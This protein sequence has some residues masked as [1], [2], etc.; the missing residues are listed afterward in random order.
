MSLVAETLSPA[1]SPASDG[2]APASRAR[3]ALEPVPLVQGELSLRQLD[4]DIFRPM[5]SFP[6]RRWWVAISIT[7]AMAGI[8]AVSL[9]WTVLFGIGTWGNNQPVGWGFGIIN[10]V[11]W[12][13]IGHA[14]TLIS[15]ILYLLRQRWRTGIARFAEAMTLFA[16]FCALQFPLLHTGR[17]WLAMFWLIPYPNGQ[18][19]YQ[20]FT[21]PLEW[22]VFA[23]GTYGLVSALFWYVGL[24]PDLATARDRA[25]HPLRKLVYG[26]L[27]LGWTGSHRAWQHYE[28]AYLLLA[29]L[30][31]P[32]VL[33]VH[34]VVSFDFA[35]SVIP[36]WHTTIFP[37]YFVAGAI[38][39]GFAMVATL[40]ILLRRFF[41]LEHIITTDAVELMNK[42][43][44]VTSLMVGYAYAME[45]FTA[46]YSGVAA[47]R[48][49]FLNRALGPYAWA[50]WTM[51]ICNVVVPQFLWIK[52][53]RRNVW[54]MY[55]IVLL[56][57]VGM[58]FERFVIV[59]TSLHRDYLPSSWGMFKPTLVDAGLMVGSFGIFLTLMLI[60]CRLLPT[61]ASTEMKALLPG[62][63][64]Q[65]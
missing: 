50:Y 27:S 43:V 19:I 33:S 58:W 2:G 65:H 35:V 6:T 14:G 40:I 57:N 28:K 15:A 46:W 13:G 21:S 63:Q 59:I 34:S 7:G 55:P 20:N 61:V 3:A 8:Y 26:L 37:P 12:V 5:E 60:F 36:G 49:V 25:K 16:V 54:L 18:S 23:V 4:D 52:K 47:E 11:F 42:I 39:S 53:V 51:V 48:Y 10:F 30:A 29:G 24:I 32:L 1:V 62:S 64:P 41:H 31:T 56:V 22:D 44:I 9:V 17:P 38:L 45:F